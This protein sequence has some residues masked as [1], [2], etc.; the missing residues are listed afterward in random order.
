ADLYADRVQ[1]TFP[2]MRDEVHRKLKEVCEQLSKLPPNL[3]TASAR[4]A[5]YHELADF[6]VENILRVR[7]TSSNDG[8]R[9]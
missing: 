1:D 4:L 6:Y 3:E 2:K 5:K 9:A 7:F 8:Q